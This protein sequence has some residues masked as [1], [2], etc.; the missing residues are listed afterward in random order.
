MKCGRTN[1][2][3]LIDGKGY[4]VAERYVPEKLVDAV[5]NKLDTLHPVRASSSSKKYAEGEQIK[6]LPDI[7]VWWSQ[8]VMDWPEVIE[9]ESMVSELV[10]P[11]L[12][13]LEWY[14]SDIVVIEGNSNWI[15]PHVDTP[16]RFKK[17]NYDK[18]LLGVQAIMSLFDL[19][20]TRGVTGV[21]PGSQNQ[22]H[23]INLCYQG[24]YNSYFSKNCLQPDLPKGSVLLYNCRALHSSMPNLQNRPRQAL[25][26]NYLDSRIID[27][28]RPMDNIWESNKDGSG[29]YE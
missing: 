7:T 5:N 21:V 19:D 3:E 27:D 20:K 23:N 12:P 29:Y 17:Y 10:K 28:I 6:D 11:Y 1:M 24:F 18:R 13:T 22:D 16:H 9:I 4:V 8:M 15:N 2:N 26:F 25:L 14:A